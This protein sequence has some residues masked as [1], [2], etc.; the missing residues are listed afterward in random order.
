[1]TDYNCTQIV[2]HS[3][4]TAEVAITKTLPNTQSIYRDNNLKLKSN[5]DWE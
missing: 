3:A 5:I 1:M 4:I 2:N